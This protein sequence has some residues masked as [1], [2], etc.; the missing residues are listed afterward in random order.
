MPIIQRPVGRGKPDPGKLKA[1]LRF[2]KKDRSGRRRAA[3]VQRGEEIC[4]STAPPRNRRLAETACKKL[5]PDLTGRS[6][7]L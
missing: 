7:W 4:G 3:L 2:R 5:S 6:V 1:D